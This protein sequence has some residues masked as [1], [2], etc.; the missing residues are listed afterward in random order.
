[1]SL[2]SIDATSLLSPEEVKHLQ[3]LPHA[4]QGV[5]S[6]RTRAAQCVG[7]VC[8][9]LHV[10]HFLSGLGFVIAVGNCNASLFLFSRTIYSAIGIGLASYGFIVAAV[11]HR[12]VLLY[13]K[14]KEQNKTKNML[15]YLTIPITIL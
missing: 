15:A 2:C 11:E 6:L 5:S 14:L 4:S 13:V 1:M 7:A 8:N 12:Y 10:L 3:T 9:G